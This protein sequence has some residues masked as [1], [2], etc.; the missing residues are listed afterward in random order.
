MACGGEAS[1]ESPTVGVG[2]VDHRVQTR[3]RM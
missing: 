1:R 3:Q 2:E